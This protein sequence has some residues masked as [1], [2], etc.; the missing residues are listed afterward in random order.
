[1]KRVLA[2]AFALALTLQAVGCYTPYGYGHA[3]L[4]TAYSPPPGYQP[5]QYTPIASGLSDCNCITP[6]QP[7]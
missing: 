2:L 7:F 3:P 1:M 4:G 5:A 6:A